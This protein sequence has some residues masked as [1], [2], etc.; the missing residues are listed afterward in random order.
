VDAA[1]LAAVTKAYTTFFSGTETVAQAEAAIQ[2]GPKLAA[3]IATQ[4]KNPTAKSLS[5]TVTSVALKNANVAN[6]IFTLN[7]NGSPLLSNTPGLAVK[8]NGVWKIAA[9][10]Y[11]GLVASEGQA[12][13][14]CSDPKVTDLPS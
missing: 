7:S 1:T 8:Q 11:C 5:V 4:A 14:Q 10:T 3:S 6:V 12:P 2:N 9:Q 13:A